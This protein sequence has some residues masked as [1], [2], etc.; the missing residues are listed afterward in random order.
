MSVLSL[1]GRTT[2][3][4]SLA[5]VSLKVFSFFLFP[6]RG[7]TSHPTTSKGSFDHQRVR[8]GTYSE[9]CFV[10]NPG[11]NL[12]R[13]PALLLLPPC[14]LSPPHSPGNVFL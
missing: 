6:M 13:S 5:S 12:E 11:D 10:G 9:C 14:P 1:A 2:L 8:T 4:K 3:G 7:A